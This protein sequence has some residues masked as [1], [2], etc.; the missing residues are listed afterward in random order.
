[1]QHGLAI[2]VPA[3]QVPAHPIGRPHRQLEIDQVTGFQSAQG[4]ALQRLRGNIRAEAFLARGD[5]GQANTVD[6]DAV[7]FRAVPHV[8]CI[9]CE[10]H[11]QVAAAILAAMQASAVCHD[12][13]EHD[14]VLPYLGLRRRR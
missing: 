9:H 13:S 14:D 10:F 5:H 7:A 11:A 3:D 4:R 6:R 12:S 2:D 1:M 8:F